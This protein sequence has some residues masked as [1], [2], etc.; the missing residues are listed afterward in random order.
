MLESVTVQHTNT[1]AEHTHA[2][3]ETQELSQKVKERLDFYQTF[4]KGVL[5][6]LVPLCTVLTFILTQA[7][8]L[9]ASTL[10]K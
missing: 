7:K 1:L 5:W 2:V 10:S 8:D 3:K 9:I 4:V 6:V